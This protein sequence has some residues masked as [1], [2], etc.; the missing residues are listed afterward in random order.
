[1][2]VRSFGR[3][4]HVPPIACLG[5]AIAFLSMGVA[6]AGSPGSELWATART[7]PRHDAV[8]PGCQMQDL[9]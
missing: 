7:A 6:E 4:L 8:R 1:M 5:E 9:R 2:G 3:I